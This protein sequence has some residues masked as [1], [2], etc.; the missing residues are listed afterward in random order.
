M[1]WRN[2][3]SRG[4]AGAAAWLCAANAAAVTV[5]FDDRAGHPGPF[6]A[7]AAQYQ[8]DDEYA[9]LGVHFASTDPAV[10]VLAPS[11]PPSAPNVVTGIASG[12]I[13]FSAPV[14]AAFFAGEEPVVF[15][16]VSVVL[17]GSSSPSAR[18]EAYDV[19]GVLL[20]S[21]KTAG[22]GTH[23]VYFPQH[24][25]SVRIAG[26]AF[27]MDDFT[28][29]NRPPAPIPVLPPAASFAL[30]LALA[31]AGARAL[32]RVCKTSPQPGDRSR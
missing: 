7:C 30:G 26:G 13:D 22:P 17:S 24:I 16:Y 32:R 31:G 21:S 25:H 15:A 2:W 9:A 4:V 12:N 10:C 19:D 11:N 1:Q 27:A 5:D 18:L 29:S 20:G 3:R 23:W 28:F 6:T 8:V 14:T